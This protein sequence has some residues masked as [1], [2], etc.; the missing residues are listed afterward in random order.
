MTE[1]ISRCLIVNDGK[2]L[3]CENLSGKHY[4]LPGGHL[5]KE[6]SPEIALGR[7]L[8][9]EIGQTP[10]KIK[11]VAEIKNSY[12][13]KRGTHDE[14]FYI[15]LVALAD[16]KNI[17]SRENHIEFE[18]VSIDSLSSIN[19]KPKKAVG[20]IINTINKNIKFW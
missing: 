8:L 6:E 4:F 11:R 12:V 1:I 16:Y 3:L 20:E 15:Y 2:I 10:L 5:E 13:D 19:F 18:W 14:T 7:E 9:E 17:K